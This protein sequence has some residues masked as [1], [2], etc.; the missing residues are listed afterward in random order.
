MRNEIKILLFSTLLL[1]VSC[2]QS[3]ENKTEYNQNRE[4]V[5]NPEG[6]Q[7]D[8]LSISEATNE[9]C[10]CAE[11]DFVGTKT[12]TVYQLSNGKR[13]ALC[14]Y[15]N[16]ENKPIDFSEFVLSVCGEKKIIDFWDATETCNLKTI[17][18]TL[19][20]EE[21][22]NLPTEKNRIYNSTIWSIEK[23]YFQN[24]Q[25]KRKKFLNQ[26]IRKY[27]N[28]EILLTL[29]EY[30]NADEK[31]N[32]EKMQLVNRLF[33]ATISKNNKARDYFYKFENRYKPDGAFS[34]EYSDLKAMLEVWDKQK[35]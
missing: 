18:D 34:E 4:L 8:N 17:K 20:V 3:G 1:F 9:D 13:I 31:L 35:Y 27:N 23:F 16:I 11:N 28:A 10:K 24:E 14:G 33:I 19:I 5:P 32:D 2:K 22:I 15:R 7:N 26:K 6:L 21:L 25:L 29:K 30:E 12:D